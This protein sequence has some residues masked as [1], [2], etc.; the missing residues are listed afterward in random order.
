MERGTH[1][2]LDHATLH[3]IDYIYISHTHTDHLDPYTLV[4]IY[5]HASP[6]LILPVTLHYLESLFR[7]YLTEVEIIWLENQKPIT[8]SGIEVTGIMFEQDEI[9]NE[10]D[11]MCISLANHHECLF[12]EIDT[13]PPETDE[14]SRIL[15][16]LMTKRE[17]DTVVYIASRNELEGNLKI[18]DF[19]TPKERE[20][21][22]REYIQS[23]K[24]EIEWSYAEWQYEESADRDN[25][26]TIAGFVRAFIGQGIVYPRSLSPELAGLTALSLEE[27]CD[28][29]NSLA[30]QYGYNF[31]QKV[32]LPGRQYRLEMGSIEP[33]R[34]ECP[35]GTLE[36]SREKT[37]I[38][39][40]SIRKYASGPLFR[41]IEWS[42][43]LEEQILTL[44][45]TL[46]LPYWSA[47]PIVSLRSALI[48]KKST[49]YTIAIQGK[50]S[51]R[52]FSYGF[53]SV[54]FSISHEPV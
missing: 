14:A 50:D 18:L 40:L 3:T 41:E 4:E 16:R 43:L 21:F 49:P 29:E 26:M 36:V 45:D 19:S 13:I 37:P 27:V 47:S 51:S 38:D 28:R 33:G 24:E 9:T 31:P 15:Y 32:L 10:D 30:L 25:I 42:P 54:G 8:L 12:A 2:R 35:I 11:V 44:L 46:F 6:V 20:N 34:K 48:K 53:G 52:Y 23:R 39:T 5:K 17:Y 7:E 22:R 1:V